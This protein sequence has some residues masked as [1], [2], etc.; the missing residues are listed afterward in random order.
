MLRMNPT[1]LYIKWSLLHLVFILLFNDVIT[2]CRLWHRFFPMIPSNSSN[3]VFFHLY[4]Q[5]YNIGLRLIGKMTTLEEISLLDL[6][7]KFMFVVFYKKT[8]LFDI[9][10][11][12]NDLIYF[13]TVVF[14]M[15]PKSS[16][17]SWVRIEIYS[18]WQHMNTHTFLTR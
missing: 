6:T 15:H 3:H 13:F 16:L 7:P 1:V 9:I 18:K 2:F 14:N 8:V 10:K 12:I 17:R 4:F 5:Y 11:K